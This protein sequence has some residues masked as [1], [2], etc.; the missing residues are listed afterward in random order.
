MKNI[1]IHTKTDKV[2]MIAFDA[3]VYIVADEADLRMGIDGYAHV[4]QDNY[5]LSP[6]DS[7][8]Y[9]FTN[10]R[11]NKL[12][13]LYWDRNGF[14]LLYK[15][16]EEKCFRWPR[17]NDETFEIS[18][19]QLNRLLSGLSIEEKGFEPLHRDYI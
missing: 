19:D 8:M 15:R 3:K 7:A 2:I 16:L 1:R 11:H 9:C 18:E 5:R 10:K 17:R 14:W 12:K 4:I 13:I 6:F